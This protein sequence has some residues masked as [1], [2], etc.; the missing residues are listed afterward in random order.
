MNFGAILA[1]IGA[2]VS[3][4]P[5]A[6]QAGEAITGLVEKITKITSKDPNAITQADLDELQAENDR[7]AEEVEKD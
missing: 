6:I 4:I 2:G 7:L 3:L 5:Q 1:A